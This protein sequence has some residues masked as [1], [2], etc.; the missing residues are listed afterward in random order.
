VRAKLLFVCITWYLWYKQTTS[1]QRNININFHWPTRTTPTREESDEGDEGGW[2]RGDEGWWR[3]DE[4]GWWRG[5][6]GRWWAQTTRVWAQ[7]CFILFSLLYLLKYINIGITH[8][9]WRHHNDSQTPPSLQTRVGGVFSF[10]IRT[11][12]RCKRETVGRYYLTPTPPSLQTRDGGVFGSYNP[13]SLQSR[14]GGPF[15]GK[16]KWYE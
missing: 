15:F 9:P 6:E 13:P 2:W 5:D 16:D 1:S 8:H 11:H 3:G 4:G 14:A 7:V 10:I 12:P